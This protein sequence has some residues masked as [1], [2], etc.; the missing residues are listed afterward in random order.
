MAPLKNSS[1]INSTVQGNKTLF[2]FQ[3]RSAV[4]MSIYVENSKHSV[5]VLLSI[6]GGTNP[7]L[8]FATIVKNWKKK[9]KIMIIRCLISL[10]SSVGASV[11][12]QMQQHQYSCHSKEV[13][14]KR[15]WFILK[16]KFRALPDFH[17]LNLTWTTSIR[18]L[19]ELQSS[20]RSLLHSLWPDEGLGNP[21]VKGSTAVVSL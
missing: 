16:R 4:S 6:A 7:Y 10:P 14:T 3:W 13:L 11:P 15:Q 9:E 17:L 21:C 19:H 20:G 8:F 2:F 12:S 18:A 5:L 1:C